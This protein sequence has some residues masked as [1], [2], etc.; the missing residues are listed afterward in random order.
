M[1]QADRLVNQYM[2]GGWGLGEDLCAFAL[3][4]NS[5]P[6]AYGCYVGHVIQWFR[7]VVA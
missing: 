4:G 2:S 7:F 6:L 1:M 3:G 5:L